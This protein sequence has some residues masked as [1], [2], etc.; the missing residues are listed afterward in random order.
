MRKGS[1]SYCTC[2]CKYPNEAH[3]CSNGKWKCVDSHENVGP[4]GGDGKSRAKTTM[5]RR[6]HGN[7]H[8]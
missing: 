7:N 8:T 5:C 2:W 4:L 6:I 3:K 1:E